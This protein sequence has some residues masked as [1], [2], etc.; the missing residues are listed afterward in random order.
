MNPRYRS[1]CTGVGA[2]Q[3]VRAHQ[4]G[5]MLT[6]Q[7]SAMIQK[8]GSSESW[9]VLRER[10]LALLV[11][12]RQFRVRGSNGFNLI[13]NSRQVL[14]SNH[15]V[16]LIF[17]QFCVDTVADAACAGDEAVA[18]CRGETHAGGA[19]QRRNP[20]LYTCAKSRLLEQQEPP[21]P[22]R[23]EHPVRA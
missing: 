5:K 12:F 3:S 18:Q 22:I 16:E 6:L 14:A 2:S 20:G 9:L 13:S 10:A 7:Q 1:I 17:P 19:A 4:L 21:R 11:I 15:H 8:L 23:E